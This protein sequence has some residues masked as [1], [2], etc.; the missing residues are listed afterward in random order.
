MDSRF[1]QFLVFSAV[2]STASLGHAQSHCE[3]P[4]DEAFL[5]RMAEVSAA[6]EAG[7]FERVLNLIDNLQE[8]SEYVMLQYAR[9]RSLHRLE[10]YTDAEH[11]YT[12]FLRQYADCPDPDN[13]ASTATQFRSLA[14]EEQRAALA[15]QAAA[16][17]AAA[18]EQAM[19]GNQSGLELRANQPQDDR[20]RPGWA[21]VI[22]GGCLVTAGVFHD[23]ANADLFEEQELA[24]ESQDET[25]FY[26]LRDD[27]ERARKVD[28][29]LYVSG[30]A[31][32]IAGIVW[33]VLDVGP[34]EP[35][36]ETGFAPVRGGTVFTFGGQF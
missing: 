36:L 30:I 10:Q 6:V 8:G 14:I 32:V 3:D 24:Q 4:T 23:L 17:A 34:E 28:L 26:T 13:L 11:A 31:F 33:V 29:G 9:A 1:L 35:S 19:V 21:F 15:D 2:L 7:D 27:I 22:V 25:T 16:A 12:E 20:F 18:A 5:A